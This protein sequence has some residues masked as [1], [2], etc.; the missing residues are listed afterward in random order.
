MPVGYEAP[1]ANE[2][3]YI[4]KRRDASAIKQSMPDLVEDWVKVP[5]QRNESSERRHKGVDV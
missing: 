1:P 5:C 2:L 3:L 4:Y